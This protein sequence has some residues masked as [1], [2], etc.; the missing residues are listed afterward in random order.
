MVGGDGVVVVSDGID[1][2]EDFA[3]PGQL[4]PGDIEIRGVVDIWNRCGSPGAL[5]IGLELTDVIDG[6]GGQDA[7]GGH[8]ANLQSI[9]TGGEVVDQD[10]VYGSD[11]HQGGDDRC[12]KRSQL[13]SGLNPS[14]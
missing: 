12:R 2:I 6:L 7:L 5:L 10:E 11:R 1:V 4:L 8:R 13:P 3:T 14:D 9:L